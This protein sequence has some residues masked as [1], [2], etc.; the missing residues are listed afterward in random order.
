MKAYHPEEEQ[1]WVALD[2]KGL[3]STLSNPNDS[4]QSFVLV[5]S[6]FGQ[7]SG[8]VYG[9]NT[10]DNGKSGEGQALDELVQTL[11]LKGTILTMDALHCTKKNLI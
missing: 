8:L 4:L 2:G 3:L 11:G 5:V 7:K 10:F 9:V 6:A 1:H